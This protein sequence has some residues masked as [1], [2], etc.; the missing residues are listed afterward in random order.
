MP[1]FTPPERT[2]VV[3]MIGGLRYSYLVSSTV[4]KDADGVWHAREVPYDGDLVGGHVLTSGGPVDVDPETADELI[5][6][7]IGT[8]TD[9]GE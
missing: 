1:V 7:G 6:A 9:P 2:Q 4:W 3:R 5:A 8:I